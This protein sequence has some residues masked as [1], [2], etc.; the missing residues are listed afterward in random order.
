MMSADPIGSSFM[1][2]VQGVAGVIGALSL[3]AIVGIWEVGKRILRTRRARRMLAAGLDLN[4]NS[5][6]DS[7]V[8]HDIPPGLLEI[9]RRMESDRQ[10]E[11]RQ[12]DRQWERI[13]DVVGVCRDLASSLQ[14]FV[15][16]FEMTH[17]GHAQA[18]KRIE[19]SQIAM[20]TWVYQ[21]WPRSQQ[22]GTYYPPPA[23]SGGN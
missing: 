9:I 21:N 8:K 10:E 2:S 12:R 18:M 14:S 5:G 17:H 13:E 7:D 22:G 20:A 23:R 19:D 15:K 1:P 3:T 11:A 16:Q 6:E 4:P